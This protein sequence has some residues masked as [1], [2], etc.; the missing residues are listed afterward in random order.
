MDHTHYAPL[1]RIP[2]AAARKWNDA[3]AVPTP[4]CHVS[5]PHLQNKHRKTTPFSKL[6]SRRCKSLTWALECQGLLFHL[7]LVCLNKTLFDTNCVAMASQEFPVWARF[8]A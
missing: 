2:G 8:A 3:D 1:V 5:E 7:A 4:A 6:E